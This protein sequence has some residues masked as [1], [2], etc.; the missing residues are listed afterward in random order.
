MES[1][2]NKNYKKKHNIHMTLHDK[3]TILLLTNTSIIF[4]R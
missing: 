1:L 2:Y 3:K 4:T